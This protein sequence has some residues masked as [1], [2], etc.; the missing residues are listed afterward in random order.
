MQNIDISFKK[1]VISKYTPKIL[2]VNETS[3]VYIKVGFKIAPDTVKQIIKKLLK[4]M[5]C[6]LFSMKKHV[7]TSNTIYEM[8]IYK[9]KPMSKPWGYWGAKYTE[10]MEV[11]NTWAYWENCKKN[12]CLQV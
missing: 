3:I 1:Y 11:G 10:I 7:M 2:S 5:R 9:I 6:F 8:V 12:Q 4:T